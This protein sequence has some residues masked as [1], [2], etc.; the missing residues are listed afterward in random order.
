MFI[1]ELE[2]E[3]L[4]DASRNVIGSECCASLC[5]GR[6]GPCRFILFQVNDVPIATALNHGVHGGHL[7]N[8]RK[9]R[10]LV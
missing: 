9:D 3:L 2:S 1:R 7:Q 8:A 6:G 10:D 5:G 4:P